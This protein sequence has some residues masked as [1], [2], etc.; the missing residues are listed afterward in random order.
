MASRAM[1][2]LGIQREGMPGARARRASAIR[3]TWSASVSTALCRRNPGSDNGGRAPRRRPLLF[4]KEL[5]RCIDED[6]APGAG[7]QIHAERHQGRGNEVDT[8][9]VTSQAGGTDLNSPAA[10]HSPADSQR[11]TDCLTADISRSHFS[12][13]PP[14]YRS[15]SDSPRVD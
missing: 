15:T 4:S 7:A 2:I 12:R 14:I 5:C 10:R 13:S 3:S 8:V 6:G 1:S 9:Q 11:Q